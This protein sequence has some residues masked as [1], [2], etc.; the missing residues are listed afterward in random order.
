MIRASEHQVMRVKYV[1]ALDDEPINGIRRHIRYPLRAMVSF[2]WRGLDGVECRGKG[3]S[4]DIS[5][6]GAYIV[7]RS[8]PPL[9][10]TIELMVRFVSMSGLARS[11]RLEL[12]GCVVRIEPLLHSKE[13]WG[14]AVASTQPILQETDDFDD[15]PDAA[16]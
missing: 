12:S 11:Y 8:C 9:R 10:A 5:E 1:D 6:G 4:R 2:K 16:R 14:F 3:D 15:G 13:N 7:T